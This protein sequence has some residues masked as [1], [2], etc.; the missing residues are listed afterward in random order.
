[1]AEVYLFFLKYG[2]HLNW[3]YFTPFLVPS[4]IDLF[5]LPI[6]FFSSL[7]FFA[8]LLYF[9]HIFL[10]Q[11][12]KVCFLISLKM[13]FLYISIFFLFTCSFLLKC[14]VHPSDSLSCCTPQTIQ[15]IKTY[16]EICHICSATLY[17][18]FL[19][20]LVK[21][22]LMEGILARIQKTW[23]WVQFWPQLSYL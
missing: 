2:W 15:Q 3:S 5:F 8:P 1:M 21:P 18:L 20:P 22:S 7:R 12:F 19:V 14:S 4:L 6:L 9:V 13:I 11:V 23:G 10:P 16:L 17:Q